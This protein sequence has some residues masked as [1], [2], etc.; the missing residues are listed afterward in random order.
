MEDLSQCWLNSLERKF[1]PETK[2]ELKLWYNVCK[3][4]E[5]GHQV[6]LNQGLKTPPSKTQSD[7]LQRYKGN[8]RGERIMEL[9]LAAF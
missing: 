2:T 6:E 8:P 7:A 3:P 1:L 9:H 4:G 5:T